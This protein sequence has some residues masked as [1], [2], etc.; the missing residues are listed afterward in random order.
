MASAADFRRIAL[1][2]EG[3]TE[4]PHF[5]RTAFKVAR[6]YATLAADGRSANFRFMPDQQALKCAVA[7]DSFTAV[8]NAWGKQGWTTGTLAK[9]TQPE[10]RD[11]L[12]IAWRHALPKRPAGGR[13]TGRKSQ[14]RH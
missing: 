11:A 2:L 5:D 12:E 8:P 7:P 3:T 13:T 14:N 10:L 9:L 6:I 4:A 1:S